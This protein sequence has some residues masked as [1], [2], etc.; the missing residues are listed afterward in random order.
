MA[1]PRSSTSSPPDDRPPVWLEAE[2]FCGTTLDG[3]YR[4]G[5]VLGVGGTAAVFGA[6][7]LGTE[8]PV[9]IKLLLARSFGSQQQLLRVLREARVAAR[10]R[11]PHVIEVRDV[12]LDSA[13][14]YIVMELLEGESLS[15]N[16]A[17]RGHLSPEETLRLTL[18]I[19]G[20]LACAHDQGILH[21]D[22]K[23]ANV[24]LATSGEG[25]RPKLLDFGLAKADHGE[26]I[27]QSG[28]VL[29]TPSF[30]SPEQARDLELGP[31][32]DVWSMGVVLFH[33]MSGTLPFKGTSMTDVLLKVVSADPE[34]LHVVNPSVPKALSLAVSR[35]LDRDPKR[36][37]PTMGALARLLLEAAVQARLSLPEDPDPQGLP[38]WSTWLRESTRE[39]LRTATGPMEPVRLVASSVNAPVE[40]APSIESRGAVRRGRGLALTVAVAFVSAL[41]FAWW[42]MRAPGDPPSSAQSA[43][44]RP[45]RAADISTVPPNVAPV[46]TESRPSVAGAPDAQVPELGPPSAPTPTGSRETR[47]VRSRRDSAG[48]RTRAKSPAKSADH[49]I[50]S[51]LLELDPSWE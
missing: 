45:V 18:P 2:S 40:S 28:T 24:F 11:H 42:S 22:L 12:S 34:P 3:K 16:I 8:Q 4:L 31:T 43:P 27:T 15:A 30:M 36:R 51:P 38:L 26:T 25:V 29:G 46:V 44:A 14:P 39:D 49:G 20:A 13:K 21:R 23:P 1:D 10:L 47:R 7:H 32:S 35:A 48:E 50:P 6:V 9:A 33:C 19:M 5:R 37:P 41:A 17:R